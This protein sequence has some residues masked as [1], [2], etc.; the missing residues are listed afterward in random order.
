MLAKN[1]VDVYDPKAF[2]SVGI[3]RIPACLLRSSKRYIHLNGL[4]FA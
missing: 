4:G 3:L 1:T 2:V